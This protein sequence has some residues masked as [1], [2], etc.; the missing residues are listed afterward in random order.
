MCKSRPT[1]PSTVRVA[2][3]ST[4]VAAAI[5]LLVMREMAAAQQLA[6]DATT[7]S[8]AAAARTKARA[9]RKLPEILLVDLKVN[10]QRVKPSKEV[11]PG[12]RLLARCGWIDA[13]LVPPASQ[14]TM[15]DGSEAHALESVAGLTYRIDRSA[16]TLE[17]QAPPG[18]YLASTLALKKATALPPKPADPGVMLNY[19]VSITRDPRDARSTGGALV[20]AIAFSSFGS[21]VASGLWTSDAKQ[22]RFQR[23]D[24]YWRYDMP[25]RMETLIVGDAI[26]TGGAW[27]RPVRL[28][29]V[30]WGRDF[31]M[32]PGFITMPQLALSGEAALP[33]TVDVMVN[34]ARRASQSVPP[35]PFDLPD[36]PVV[37][38]AG[39]VSLVLRDML[40]R[41]TLVQH[42][43]YASPRLLAPGLV[44]F[45]LEAGRLRTGYG[46]DSCY[47][48]VFAA[49]TVRTGMTPSLTGEA[50]LEL[51][52]QRRAVGVEVAGLLGTWA[53]ARGAL[54]ASSDSLQGVAE[55]GRM[56]LAGI[57]RSSPGGNASL[58]YEYATRG[59]APLGEPATAQVTGQRMRE[60]WLAAAGGRV[61]GILSGGVNL[62]RQTRWDGDALTSVGL[63]ASMPLGGQAHLGIALNKRLDADR[64]WTAAI[65]ITMPLHNGA[66]TS[67][68]LQRGSDGRVVGEVSASMNP[69]PG[70]GLGWRVD[71]STEQGGR[72]R[73]GLQYN[74]NS[75][76][77][78]ADASADARGEVALRAGARGTLGWLGGVL[79]ASRPV[80]ERSVA[81]VE[82]EGLEG[83]PVR[84]S[85]QVVATT[86]SRGLAFIAGLLPWQAN[87]LEIDPVDLP[88]DVEIGETVQAVVPYPRSGAVV[89]F[90]MRRTRQVVAV[91]SQSGGQP[92]PEGAIV[93]LDGG[94]QFIVGRRGEV[95]LTDLTLERQSLAVRW[96]RG[97]CKV[98]FELPA[99]HDGM[100]AKIGPLA[101][102]AVAP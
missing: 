47:G 97:A 80:G 50:R 48:E 3:H 63:S 32:R 41:E 62:L 86:D 18:A 33:S 29:G 75:A 30:R 13:R 42:S 54:A 21:L 98:T 90:A 94:A 84:R 4:V 34:N 85:N 38:G 88:M 72:A 89:K 9:A 31:G 70:P 60:R 53:V 40:G 67:T 102:E 26:S 71:A 91:L 78:T 17:I 43:Y 46:A 14:R 15:S 73:G 95:W 8:P 2:R 87:K 100:P 25:E 23:L 101:C 69:P 39:Q 58:Q 6:A 61:S 76:E 49:G 99:A 28:G 27:S 55:Q 65:N 11:A 77:F 7:A 82:V 79:F 57:E 81:L 45:S 96:S 66:F 35:G 56:I 83:V 36:V 24:T 59:F 1:R 10:G 20:E 5:L 64:S 68:R 44:D 22:S 16:L 74:T 19:D 12:D 52:A 37:T 92:V 93:R 51:Q